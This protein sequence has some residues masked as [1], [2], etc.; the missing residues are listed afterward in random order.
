MKRLACYSNNRASRQS[1]PRNGAPQKSEHKQ[2][3]RARVLSSHRGCIAGR[4]TEPPGA[5]GWQ[6]Y[7]GRMDELAIWKRA[8]T[9]DEVAEEVADLVRRDREADAD[10]DA[11][12][13]ADRDAA[14]DADHLA[15]LVEQGAAG[16]AR[17]R[18]RASSAIPSAS[19]PN[20]L[21]STG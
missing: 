4:G 3:R 14:V 7:R 10:V 2:R 15:L 1:A 20:T 17:R 13:V 9:G 11:A 21:Q 12:A 19:E 16:V 6:A 18:R 5:Y 8:L